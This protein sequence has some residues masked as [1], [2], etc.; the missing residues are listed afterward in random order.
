MQVN[1]FLRQFKASNDVIV[2]LIK[3][4][5]AEKIGAEKLKGLIK[6]IP[7]RDEV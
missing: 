2:G 3:E 4:G 6:I 7:E 1:I 5:D